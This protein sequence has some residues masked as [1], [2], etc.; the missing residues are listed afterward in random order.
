MRTIHWI[1][2]VLIGLTS[3][4]WA[5]A[6]PGLINYQGVLRD[7]SGSPLDVPGGLEMKFILNRLDISNI[8]NTKNFIKNFSVNYEKI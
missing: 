6:P 5:A 4:L 3:L 1:G 8:S 2:L 7:A